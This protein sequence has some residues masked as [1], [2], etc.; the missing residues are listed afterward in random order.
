V[1]LLLAVVIAGLGGALIIDAAGGFETT[2][3]LWL[4]VAGFALGVLLTASVRSWRP[5]GDAIATGSEGLAGEALGVV[6]GALVG[7]LAVLIVGRPAIAIGLAVA[8]GALLLVPP[9][10]A[11]I[12]G[13][14]G[15]MSRPLTGT[16]ATESGILVAAFA[17]LAALVVGLTGVPVAVVA[18]VL[19]VV[20]LALVRRRSIA[21]ISSAAILL[22]L[23]FFTAGP[24][25]G[26]ATLAPVPTPAPTP[27]GIR[28]AEVQVLADQPITDTG[29]DLLPGDWLH[30]VASGDVRL[31][32]GDDGSVVDADGLPARYEGCPLQRTCGT[33]LASLQPAVGWQ[34]MGSEGL[35]AFAGQGRLYLA[36][37]DADPSDNE[38]AFTVTIRAGPADLLN[39]VL[40]TP[41]GIS[42]DGV[43]TDE[44]ASELSALAVSGASASGAPAIDLVLAAGIGAAGALVG[45]LM[46]RRASLLGIRPRP[47]DADAPAFEPVR[48]QPAGAEAARSEPEP[49]PGRSA[50]PK[51]ATSAKPESGAGAEDKPK[52]AV[53]SKA[54]AKPK[55]SAVPKAKASAAAPPKAAARPSVEPKSPAADDGKTDGRGKPPVASSAAAPTAGTKPA[56]RP[57]KKQAG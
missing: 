2:D 50:K 35:I 16:A 15:R 14:L 56:K 33:L 26:Q 36:V 54:G 4:L 49:N 34:P 37:N 7:L 17:A 8:L 18:I 55:P 13:I 12:G 32:A 45:G 47:D 57:R 53:K 1:T 27:G 30:V 28:V 29:F 11:M 48:D 38:G 46:V 6:V 5:I 24:T 20:V 42:R 44:A 31:V 40:P 3:V 9:V 10:A 19:S 52:P 22:G 41:T 51:S 43:L 25:V 39:V 23:T 21:A